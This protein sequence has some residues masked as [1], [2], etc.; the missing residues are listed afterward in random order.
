M[1]LKVLEGDIAQVESDAIITAVNS[2]GMWFGGVDGVIQRA[3]GGFF[4][5]Q[6]QKKLPLKQGD[7][8]VANGAS[9][10]HRGAFTNVV[11]VID[12]LQAPLAEVVENG[13]SAASKAGF[14]SVTVPT[15]RMGVMLGAVEKSAAEAIDQMGQGV[16]AFLRKNI[17]TSIKSIS[18]VVYRDPETAA[19]L[20]Q[21][22]GTVLQTV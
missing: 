1:D 6:A 9:H 21:R 10:E 11:F 19:L 16:D 17:G 2:E 20:R 4:H 22:L 12:D 7:T 18:F 15:I 14:A 8:V 13:L 5:A 3:A